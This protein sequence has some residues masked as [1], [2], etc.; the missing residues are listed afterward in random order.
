[1]YVKKINY[2][3]KYKYILQN[4]PGIINKNY[5]VLKFKIN[6]I[7]IPDNGFCIFQVVLY[8]KCFQ[9]NVFLFCFKI[10][11]VGLHQF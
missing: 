11:V 3:I 1:M 9:I 5:I 10:L 7:R 4:S 6:K 8:Y 2:N